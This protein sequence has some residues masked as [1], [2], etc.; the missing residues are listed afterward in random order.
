M[1]SQ[2]AMP[3]CRARALWLSVA[4]LAGCTAANPKYCEKT[5]DCQSGLVCDL[6]H[7]RCIA[8]DTA[9][10]PLDGAILTDAPMDEPTTGDETQPTDAT[11]GGEVGGDRPVAADGPGADAPV[12]TRVP[13]AAGT[14]GVNGD[15]TDPTKAFCVASV[16]VGCQSAGVSACVAPTPACD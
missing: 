13:D 1:L 16:C 9:V 15:C 5:S 4:L 10:A 11:A 12:D 3:R 8:S 6:P 7:N 14:C 2:N